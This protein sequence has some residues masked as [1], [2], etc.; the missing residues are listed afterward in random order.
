MPRLPPHFSSDEMQFCFSKLCRLMLAAV[1]PTTLQAPKQEWVSERTWAL[2]EEK[3][4]IAK[5]FFAARRQCKWHFLG[6]LFLGW[7]VASLAA[8]ALPPFDLLLDLDFGL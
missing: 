3:A 8:A 1:C 7:K 6:L 2:M 4:G 5:A